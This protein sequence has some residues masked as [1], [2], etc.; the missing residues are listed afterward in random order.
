MEPGCP[1]PSPRDLKRKILIKNRRLKPEAEQSE[2]RTIAWKVKANKPE[3]VNLNSRWDRAE[4]DTPSSL[5]LFM[6]MDGW[7]FFHS[8]Q[9]IVCCAW[10][11]HVM[12]YRTKSTVSFAKWKCLCDGVFMQ[13]TWRNLRG[14]WTQMKLTPSPAS[15][16]MKANH[17]VVR[18][19]SSY[20]WSWIN[21]TFWDV[22]QP[23]PTAE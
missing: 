21:R 4:A 16:R 10:E 20:L 7:R 13:R 5:V 6:Q 18:S 19:K 11:V 3:S 14:T 1:L 23:S 2:F 8:P 22:L 17:L 9:C 15:N 12:K